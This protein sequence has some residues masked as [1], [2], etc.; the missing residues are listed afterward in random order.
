MCTDYEISGGNLPL[1]D[2]LCVKWDVGANPL[3]YVRWAIQKIHADIIER[4]YRYNSA[5]F[6]GASGAAS[7]FSH[8]TQIHEY[9]RY[10]MQK[11]AGLYFE[12]VSAG[13]FAPE[14]LIA[15]MDSTRDPLLTKVYYEAVL[16]IFNFCRKVLNLPS[17]VC[18]LENPADQTVADVFEFRDLRNRI[19][20]A[21]NTTVQSCTD[22]FPLAGD[23]LKDIGSTQD[24]TGKKFADRGVELDGLE[25]DLDPAAASDKLKQ[26]NFSYYKEGYLFTDTN[27]LYSSGL[28]DLKVAAARTLLRLGTGSMSVTKAAGVSNVTF[29][30]FPWFRDTLYQ[31]IIARVV[32]GLSGSEIDKRLEGTS[33]RF[34][35]YRE[36]EEFLWFEL[37]SLLDAVGDPRSKAYY[38]TLSLI[39]MRETSQSSF[40]KTLQE[41]DDIWYV[42]VKNQYYLYDS[43]DSFIG[44][45]LR[46][47][48]QINQVN[49]VETLKATLA[50]GAATEEAAIATAIAGAADSKA[51]LTAIVGYLKTKKLSLQP[52]QIKQLGTMLTSTV[53]AEIVV[54]LRAFLDHPV[55]QSAIISQMV[56]KKDFDNL[57][58]LNA[59]VQGFIE[60]IY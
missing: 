51:M 28:L 33:Q 23:A 42:L 14:D 29:V 21:K 22:A 56:K 17:R 20:D 35:H 7:Y 46:T 4:G 38:H 19:F 44:A 57:V 34:A 43:N 58:A 5:A 47:M 48:V 59:I 24:L 16:E 13:D 26:Y 52:P 55:V 40:N 53:P 12:K 8:F 37:M 32:F 1:F 36:Y 15:L 49:A 6:S 10:L 45:L 30:D 2:P 25:L 9:F 54:T 39:P 60:S 27:P 31:D 18:V 11:Q 50:T 3:E 41:Q